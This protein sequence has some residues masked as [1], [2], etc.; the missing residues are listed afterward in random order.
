MIGRIAPGM[1]I[2]RRL[3]SY[4]LAGAAASAVILYVVVHSVAV[5]LARES[6]DNILTASALSILDNSRVQAGEIVVDIPYF[7]FS[8]LGTATDER[9]FY[10]IWLG[11]EFLS[12]Y[13]ELPRP[14]P[15]DDQA[16]ASARFL[17]EDV[18]IMTAWRPISLLEGSS[19]LEV[20][21]AQT[22]KG[23]RATLQRVSR[24]ALGIGAGFFGLSALLALVV[25]N[26]TIRPVNRLAQSVSRRGPADLRPVTTEVP[27][28]MAPLAAALNSFMGR[29]QTSLSRSEDFIAEAAHRV[30]T[31]LALVRTQS[32]IFLRRADRPEDRETLRGMVRAIDETSRTAGQLLDHAMVSFRSDHLENEAIQ[33]RVLVWDAVARVRPTS[34]LKEI[35][36]TVRAPEDAVLQGD[37]ILLQ[38]ALANLLDN[39]VKYTP[40]EGR[41]AVT[42]STGTGQAVLTIRDSGAGFPDLETAG[43]TTRFVRGSNAHGIVGSGLGL[44]IA[45]DVVRVHGGTLTLSNTPGGGACVTLCFPLP[46][47]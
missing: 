28:E 5:Q 1:S 14:E 42:V 7:A 23:Q 9:V 8:M 24:I 38:S 39:A 22:L 29:L 18:R 35:E 40:A 17:G 19:V 4:L 31:P 3:L 30:R 36:I 34:D 45:E 26:A 13:A 37:P 15:G 20:S 44:T 2:R 6:Q 16:R 46:P 43:L 33:L 25:A 12:G 32:E 41:V 47:A 21:V 11:D 10:A 27:T